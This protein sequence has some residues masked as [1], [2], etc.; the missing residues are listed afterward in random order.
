MAEEQKKRKNPIQNT[1]DVYSNVAKIN[2]NQHEFEVTFG[3]GSSNYE[4]IKPVVNMRMSPSFCKELVRV[5]QQNVDT[6][7][8]NFGEISD[9]AEQA[10]KQ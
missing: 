10:M 1:P 2:F 9:L 8:K 5:L 3:L 6:F 7:E 4:G